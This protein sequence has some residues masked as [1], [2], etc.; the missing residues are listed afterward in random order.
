MLVVVESAGGSLALRVLRHRL[1]LSKANACEVT[2]AL[3][4]PRPGRRGATDL[5]DRRAY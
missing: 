5:R 4:Q 3:E 2:S 1:S